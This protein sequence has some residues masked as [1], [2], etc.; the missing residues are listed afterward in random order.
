MTPH[1]CETIELFSQNRG[2]PLEQDKLNT[3]K[4]H[5]ERHWRAEV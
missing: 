3:K 5:L 1:T 2:L 4:A